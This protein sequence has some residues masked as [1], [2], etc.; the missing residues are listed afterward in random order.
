MSDTLNKEDISKELDE[1][2]GDIKDVTTE[3]NVPLAA[4]KNQRD[5]FNL[6]KGHNLLGWCV[7][8]IFV[9]FILDFFGN[10]KANTSQIIEIFK[11]MIFT[12]SGYLY[13]KK[14]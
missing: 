2:L 8:F 11:V 14:K 13:G 6:Q 4:N 1:P 5:W 10:S 3:H 7:F 12:L 9:I